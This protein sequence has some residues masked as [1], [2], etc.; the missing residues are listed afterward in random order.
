[1]ID[2]AGP[3]GVRDLWARRDLAKASGTLTKTLPSHGAALYR[4]SPG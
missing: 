1:M 3:V 4:L 2:L